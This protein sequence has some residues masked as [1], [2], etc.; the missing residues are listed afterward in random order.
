MVRV[1]EPSVEIFTPLNGNEILKHL[2]RCARNCYKSEDKITDESAPKMIK[3]LI[4]NAH[5]LL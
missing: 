5:G 3:K 1:I 2:E 4:E